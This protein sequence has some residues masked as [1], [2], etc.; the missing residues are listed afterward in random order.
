MLTSPAHVLLVA[1]DRIFKYPPISLH[2]EGLWRLCLHTGK[3]MLTYYI[4]P[5]TIEFVL[6]QMNL[7]MCTAL[8]I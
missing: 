2:V 8:K 1:A 3:C 7:D 5:F 4:F 6:I